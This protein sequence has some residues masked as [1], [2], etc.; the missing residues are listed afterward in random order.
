MSIKPDS[1]QD[2]TKIEEILDLPISHQRWL[3][4]ELKLRSLA[5]LWTELIDSYFAQDPSH[6]R[7]LRFQIL[8]RVKKGIDA[9]YLDQLK[10]L[11]TVLGQILT[12]CGVILYD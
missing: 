6:L 3:E 8:K 2:V 7:R 5:D 10:L 4:K 1:I 11:H 12:R 9:Q